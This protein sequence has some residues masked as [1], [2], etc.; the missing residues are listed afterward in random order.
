MIA[1]CGLFL[2]RSRLSAVL[3]AVASAK[4][5]ALSEGGSSNPRP[6][7]EVISSPSPP[8]E[9]RRRG[10]GRGGFL[11]THDS[12]GWQTFLKLPLS[13][14]LSPL[15]RGEREEKLQPSAGGFEDLPSLRATADKRGR[16]R[17]RERFGTYRV[18]AKKKLHNQSD[19][20]STR[21]MG[22]PGKGENMSHCSSRARASRPRSR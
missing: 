7:A 14:A 13:P 16:G 4:A 22:V 21:P 19:R 8:E 12:S 1:D 15:S 3:S 5:E 6:Q 10:L 18:P 9:R 20:S 11:K 2:S 17:E